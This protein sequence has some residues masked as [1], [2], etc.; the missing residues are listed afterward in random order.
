MVYQAG[1]ISP[2]KSRP[3]YFYAI[4][5]I[6]LVLYMLGL[7]GLIMFHANKLSDYFK[8]NIQIS[9]ILKDNVKEA[10][11]AQFKSRL[12]A[13]PFLKSSEYISK[14]DAAKKF[15][16]QNKEDFVEFL[17]YNPLYGSIDL[18]LHAEY[19]NDDSL[20]NIEQQI[21]GNELVREFSYQKG[22]VTAINH[23]AKRIGLI[24][25]AISVVL[26]IIAIASIDS[27]T[28]LAMYSNRFLIKSMQLVGAT[29]WF[30]TRP[31]I[32]RSIINGSISGIVAGISLAGTLYY[33][34]IQIPELVELWDIQKLSGLFL[35]IFLIG[36]LISW[37]STHRSVKKYIKMKL[38]DLY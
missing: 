10:D 9:I 3:T 35:F 38:E 7:L 23:N 19:A 1:K 17:G 20:S 6:S 36:I 21:M 13:E 5:S 33:A 29:R 24:L 18:F 4:L 32:S 14:E 37:W 25:I 26:L 8:E 12:D 22:I 2:K 34:Q 27:T 30:I 28:R 15:M 31:F 16:E 11:I